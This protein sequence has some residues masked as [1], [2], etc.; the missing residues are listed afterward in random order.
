MKKY[1]TIILLFGFI[2]GSILVYNMF[3]VEEKAYKTFAESGYILQSK[4]DEQNE[5][6]R[7]YFSRGTKI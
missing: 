1:I 2:L 7:Y 5:V 3:K 6:E 4:T